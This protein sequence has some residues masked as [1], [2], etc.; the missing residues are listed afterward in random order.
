MLK[1]YIQLTDQAFSKTNIL[2][3]LLVKQIKRLIFKIEL[4]FKIQPLKIRE[5]KFNLN[6]SSLMSPFSRLSSQS[7]PS[8]SPPISVAAPTTP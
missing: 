8:S 7:P 1:T 5:L 3:K 6:L 2:N 4:F